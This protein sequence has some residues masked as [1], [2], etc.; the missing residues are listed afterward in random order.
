M[1]PH[2]RVFMNRVCGMG[3]G[4]GVLLDGSRAAVPVL[5]KTYGFTVGLKNSVR[6]SSGWRAGK[7]AADL[8]FA[9]F[10]YFTAQ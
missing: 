4:A 10:R 2:G 9:A 3:G 7:W 1:A 8:M 6:F 5:G